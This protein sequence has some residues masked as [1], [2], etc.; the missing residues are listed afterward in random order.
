MESN[1]WVLTL[2]AKADAMH[3]RIPS[4]Q[5]QSSQTLR[6][7]PKYASVDSGLL[8]SRPILRDVFNDLS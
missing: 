5:T 8:R 7:G 1:K 4:S 6:K 3:V 2:P